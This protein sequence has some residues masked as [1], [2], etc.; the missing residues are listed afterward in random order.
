M[1]YFDRLFLKLSTRAKNVLEYNG[2]G[3]EKEFQYFVSIHKDFKSLR[4]SGRKTNDEILLMKNEIINYYDEKEIDDGSYLLDVNEINVNKS[5]NILRNAL[6]YFDKTAINIETNIEIDDED[7]SKI[8]LNHLERFIKSEYTYNN[9]L[10]IDKIPG[11]TYSPE[12]LKIINAN[13]FRIFSKLSRSLRHINIDVEYVVTVINKSPNTVTFY[14]PLVSA[15]GYFLVYTDNYIYFKK[16]N[17]KLISAVIAH[18]KS[19]SQI[20]FEIDESIIH[21][22]LFLVELLNYFNCSIK[23]KQ[24]VKNEGRSPIDLVYDYL[25]LRGQSQKFNDIIDHFGFN[26]ETSNYLFTKLRRESRFQKIGKT[27]LISLKEWNKGELSSLLIGTALEVTKNVLNYYRINKISFRTIQ[28]LLKS[29]G[30]ITDSKTYYSN[31]Q[32]TSKNDLRISNQV[33]YSSL[34]YSLNVDHIFNRCLEIIKDLESGNFNQISQYVQYLLIIELDNFSDSEITRVYRVKSDLR[35]IGFNFK[36]QISALSRNPVEKEIFEIVF[37]IKLENELTNLLNIEQNQNS[38]QFVK[39]VLENK[40][41]DYSEHKLILD[42]I[43]EKPEQQAEII[44]LISSALSSKLVNYSKQIEVILNSNH[45][46]MTDDSVQ[47]ELQFIFFNTIDNSTMGLFMNA[48][49]ELLRSPGDLIR[50]SL[51]YLNCFF[52]IKV[53]KSNYSGL[54]ID[55]DHARSVGMLTV[56]YKENGDIVQM[57]CHGIIGHLL[58]RNLIN[59]IEIHSHYSKIE[60]LIALKQI[61]P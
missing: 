55:F 44:N 43:N 32:Q 37:Q 59:P 60:K 57:I 22:E 7:I 12:E 47:N 29:V 58:N 4:N 38:L 3:T 50:E 8:Y 34:N 33:I 19:K 31:I 14:K 5:A 25:L 46:R 41:I 40:Y 16:D 42:F 11:Q 39:S 13:Q 61:I 26:Q 10:L 6:K 27:G 56:K 45:S 17:A 28:N 48:M 23:N 21:T 36:E 51:G 24:I 20:S 1:D 52:E 54:L 35:H 2:L 30:W 53:N 15:L 9:K 18:I 49:Q